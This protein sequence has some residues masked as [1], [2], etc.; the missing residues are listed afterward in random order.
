MPPEL[1]VDALGTLLHILLRYLYVICYKNLLIEAV[2][3]K[4][5]NVCF[6]DKK[7]NIPSIYYPLLSGALLSANSFM[8]IIFLVL[9]SFT[10]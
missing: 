4:S 9:N 8:L 10:T 7:G 6:L 2:I 5:Y 1:V 3:M